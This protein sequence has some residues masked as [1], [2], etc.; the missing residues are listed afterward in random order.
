MLTP[1]TFAVVLGTFLLAG[2]VKGTVGLGLPTVSLALL[3]TILGHKEAMALILVPSLVTNLWQAFAGGQFRALV[4]RLWSLL[5]MAVVGTWIGTGL[6]AKTDALVAAGIFGAV[7]SL[8]AAYSLLTPQIPAPG[9]RL[10]R[11]LSPVMGLAGG[12][13]TGLFGAFI[14]PGILYVQALGLSRELFVQALGI[15]FITLTL[16]L[17]AGLARHAMLTGDLIILSAAAL[18]PTVLGMVFGQRVRK[19]LPE[20]RFRRALFV[21]LL[22]IGLYAGARALLA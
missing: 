14:L 5:A 17:G 11:W 3:S 6:L 1:E 18:A 20:A 21:V 2:C 16:A 12:F 13:C 9:A 4:K 10:E 22:A 19:R 7:L 15:I 8:Y